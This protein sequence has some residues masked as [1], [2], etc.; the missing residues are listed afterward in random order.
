MDQVLNQY[1]SFGAK[2]G[3]WIGRGSGVS[4]SKPRCVRVR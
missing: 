3:D 1:F 4:F 2:R